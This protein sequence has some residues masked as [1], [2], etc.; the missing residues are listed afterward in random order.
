M[1][2]QVKKNGVTIEVSCELVLDWTNSND[3]IG[4]LVV[5]GVSFEFEEG[6]ALPEVILRAEEL[7]K[8]GDYDEAF[9][10]LISMPSIPNDIAMVIVEKF[11]GQKPS[12]AS[13]WANARKLIG[14]VMVH[15]PSY[16]IQWV[17]K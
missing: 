1:F 4:E 9:T 12:R 14:G 16:S 7:A 11:Y 6:A 8:K 13:I 5:N 2:V 10:L 15:S 17:W 3:V